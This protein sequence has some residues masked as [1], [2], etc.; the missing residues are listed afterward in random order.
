MWCLDIVCREESEASV[1][2]SDPPAFVDLERSSLGQ[3]TRTRETYKEE[4]DKEDE[5]DKEEEEDKDKR[6]NMRRMRRRTKRRSRTRTRKTY[7]RI[8]L[9]RGQ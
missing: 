3:G 9:T 7:V 1:C 6:D 5:K 4:K 8:I 2:F